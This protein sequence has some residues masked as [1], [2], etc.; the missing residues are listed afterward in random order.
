MSGKAGT[1]PLD[2]IRVVHLASLG[3]GPYGAMLLADMGAE[4]IIVDRTAPM[5]VSVAPDRDPRRRGQRSVALN[6]KNP[7]ALDL[8]LD[9][10][11]SADVL[12]EGMRPGAAERLG[13]GPKLCCG[14]NKG[15]IYV[16]VTGWGQEGPLANRAGHDINYVALSGALLAMGSP[17]SPP[18]VPLNLIGDYAGGGAFVAMGV[19]AAIVARARTG[20]GQVLDAAMVDGVASLTTA[21]LGALAAGEWGPRGTNMLDGGAPWYRC[22]TTLDGGY[23]AVGALEPQFYAALMQGLGFVPDR[24]DRSDKSLW[25]EISEAFA[26]RF[27][28]ETRDHWD[29][30]FA[31]TDACVTPVLSFEEAARHPHH[32]AHGTYLYNGRLF[33][34][35]PT[36]R[37]GAPSGAPASPPAPGQDTDAV[38]AELGLGR[39]VIADLRANGAV[40]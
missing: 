3:P 12:I 19:M 20:E 1:R 28:A 8:L 36:P 40:I 39:D 13:V 5:I 16:R 38:L 11:D 26:A 17:G 29:R 23:V 37:V 7:Q 35:A 18:P 31:G 33:Q 10:I 30:V 22:Y 15:L 21:A 25:P 4:V 27:A 24:W 6:L 32:R 34:P 2:G 9:L 14:R